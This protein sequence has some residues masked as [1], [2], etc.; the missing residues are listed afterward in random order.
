M[1]VITDYGSSNPNIPRISNY[2]TKHILEPEDDND[3]VAKDTE[4]MDDLVRYHVELDQIQKALRSLKDRKREIKTLRIM[5]IR[6]TTDQNSVRGIK[7]EVT[8][9]KLS[10]MIEDELL[11]WRIDARFMRIGIKNLSHYFRSQ[12]VQSSGQTN[13][14]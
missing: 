8:L 1:N 2:A 12:V 3:K 5:T 13:L 4:M 9:D 7:I 10:E 11:E 14:F 6:N